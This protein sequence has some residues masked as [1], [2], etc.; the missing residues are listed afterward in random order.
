M[1]VAQM[2]DALPESD[3]L[4]VQ[5]IVRKLV[6]AW[7]P[8]YTKVSPAERKSIDEAERSGFIPEEEID[9]D[10]LWKYA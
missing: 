7:D 8:D 1:N 10:N 9:W 4:L 5:E 6:I 2:M 3:Q